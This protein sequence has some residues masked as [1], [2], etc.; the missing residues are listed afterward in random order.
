MKR[1]KCSEKSLTLSDI[2]TKSMLKSLHLD[3]TVQTVSHNTFQGS[4]LETHC[5]RKLQYLSQV[6]FEE[7]REIAPFFPE[8]DFL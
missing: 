4:F 2:V 1:I 3:S 6:G 5:V 8:N 7:N